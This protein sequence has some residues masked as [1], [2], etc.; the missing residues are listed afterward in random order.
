MTQPATSTGR[1]FAGR[2]ADERRSERRAQLLAAAR[3][4]YGERGY[5]ASTVKSVCDA[6]GLTE[7]YFYESFANSEDL[8]CACFQQDADALL[9]AVRRAGRKTAA[10]LDKARAG[11]VVYLRNLQERPAAAQVFLMEMSSVSPRADRLVSDNLARFG[12]LLVEIFGGDGSPPP[13]PLLVRGCIGGGLHIA[14]AWIADGYAEPVEIV[15]DTILRLYV[16]V[17]QA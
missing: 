3:R 15:A 16:L 7:R 4:V 9:E 11:L 13:S 14:Q 5:R 8:L 17:G 2:T 12:A 6:A 10:P 1:L